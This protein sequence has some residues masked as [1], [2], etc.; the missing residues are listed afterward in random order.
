MKTRLLLSIKPQFANAILCGDKRYEYR[1]SLFCR[2]GIE[3]V[4]LYSS[5]P[6]QCVIGEFLIARI[7]SLP[8]P[9]LWRKTRKYAGIK[10]T[11]F[12]NYFRG[13]SEGHAIEVISPV[14][15]AEPLDLLR[16]FGLARPP[17]SFC[18]IGEANGPKQVVPH[19]LSHRP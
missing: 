14:R 16:D 3:R 8:P 4:L 18:Y 10:R 11:D 9:S 12:D 2:P 7:L 6:D 5:I 19:S 15:F 13:K 17:Q 1:R